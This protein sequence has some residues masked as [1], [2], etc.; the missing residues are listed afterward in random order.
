MAEWLGHRTWNP[1]VAGSRPVLTTK[2]ELFL[3]RP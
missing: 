3:G 1:E 2:V